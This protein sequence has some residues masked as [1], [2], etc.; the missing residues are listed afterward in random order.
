MG[1]LIY[2]LVPFQSNKLSYTADV[3]GASAFA[4]WFAPFHQNNRVGRASWVRR[5]P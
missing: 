3:L 1:V 4:F 2:V 5:P